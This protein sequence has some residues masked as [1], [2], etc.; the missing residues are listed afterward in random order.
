[1][2]NKFFIPTKQ[3][4]LAIEVGGIAPDFTG[5]LKKVTEI[6][7]KKRDINGKWFCCYY[8][9]FGKMGS[10]SHSLKEDKLDLT[11]PLCNEYTSHELD[12]IEKEMLSAR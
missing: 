3:D 5:K 9:E 1:M 2:T 12:D 7:A 10:I 8:T 6:T 4:I 11:L